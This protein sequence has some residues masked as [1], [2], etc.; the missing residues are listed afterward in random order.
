MTEH[1]EEQRA[2]LKTTRQYCALIQTEDIK[3]ITTLFIVTVNC[4]IA[5]CNCK[6]KEKTQTILCSSLMPCLLSDLM[7]QFF[8][9]V[10]A[11][12]RREVNARDLCP[13]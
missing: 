12:D 5:K 9:H 3:E 11:R 4:R 6:D 13:S 2:V 10:G 7:D 8:T 1:H